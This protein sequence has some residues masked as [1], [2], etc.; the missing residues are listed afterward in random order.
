M[1]IDTNWARWIKNSLADYFNIGTAAAFTPVVTFFLE[2]ADKPRQPTSWF[3]MRLDGPNFQGITQD[4]WRSEFVVNVICTCYE[5]S[6]LYT[7]DDMTGAIDVL[8]SAPIT[9]YKNGASMQDT[10]LA[11][12][13]I[14]LASE[15]KTR[16]YGRINPNTRLLQAT[17]E[18]KY[19]VN[20]P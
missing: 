17:V 1:S 5:Q 18:A 13:C 10:G 9:V 6:Q 3:E 4:Q 12:A 2:G 20:L 8:M 19:F 16:P 7:I 11:L 15:I 14:T